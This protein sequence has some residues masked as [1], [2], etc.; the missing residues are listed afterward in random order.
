MATTASTRDEDFDSL[1]LLDGEFAAGELL[2]VTGTPFGLLV[3]A[4]GHVASRVAVGA[5]ATLAL[6]STAP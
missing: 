6:V 3:D 1:A 4:A 5:D 2:G